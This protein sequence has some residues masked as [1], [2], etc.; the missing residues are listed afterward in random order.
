MQSAAST[1]DEYLAGLS[2]ERREF[3]GAVRD[4][5]NARLPDGYEEGMQYGMIGWYVPLSIYPPG[6]HTGTNQPLPYAALAS[7]SA[8]VSL[9][10]MGMYTGAT[11]QGDPADVEW[12]RT[13][14]TATGRK[15]N[16]GKSCVRMKRLS[17]AALDV[18]GEAVARIPMSDYIARY[19]LVRPR[20]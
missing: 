12:L 4:A 1:V 7:Q 19:E 14:W 10:L 20:R 5:V 13:A 11:G 15:L 2:P 17:D 16:M 6:Y 8:Y 18:I 9:Y 3:V